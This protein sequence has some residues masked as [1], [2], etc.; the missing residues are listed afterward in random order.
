MSLL[1]Q[2]HPQ[3]GNKDTVWVLRDIDLALGIWYDHPEFAQ[4]FQSVRNKVIHILAQHPNKWASLRNALFD[5]KNSLLERQDFSQL[6]YSSIQWVDHIHWEYQRLMMLRQLLL[7]NPAKALQ[8]ILDRTHAILEEFPFS[9]DE[10]HSISTK[11]NDV[12][13]TTFTETIEWIRK[14][15]DHIG[16]IS[17]LEWCT[18]QWKMLSQILEFAQTER[19]G[20]DWKKQESMEYWDYTNIINLARTR[21]RITTADLGKKTK[22]FTLSGGAWNAFVQLAII[23]KFVEEE[24]GGDFSGSLPAG[25]NWKPVKTDDGDGAK[26]YIQKGSKMNDGEFDEEAPF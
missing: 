24:G 18:T 20:H 10:I 14:K 26:L 4:L 1:W 15:Y 16:I 2:L 17:F 19:A 21:G 25:G 3:Y 6:D 7:T 23:Q 5:A 8:S 13:E 9:V 11:V 22:S 12:T